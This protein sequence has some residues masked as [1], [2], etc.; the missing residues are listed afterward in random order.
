MSAINTQP[1]NSEKFANYPRWMI[2]MRKKRTRKVS[3]NNVPLSGPSEWARHFLYFYK[4]LHQT[5]LFSSVFYLDVYYYKSYK[6]I[7]L[8]CPSLFSWDRHF[9]HIYK[10]YTFHTKPDLWD[11]FQWQKTSGN[12][13]W[14]WSCE[15]SCL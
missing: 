4:V 2:W 8:L 5:R 13:L 14:R 12:S 10:V 3:K 9:L 1:Y 7:S 15:H 11:C 6:I